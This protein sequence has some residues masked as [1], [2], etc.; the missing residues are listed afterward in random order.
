MYIR[1]SIT[2]G[3]CSRHILAYYLRTEL[4]TA[5]AQEFPCILMKKEVIMHS[6]IHKCHNDSMRS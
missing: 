2:R 3:S 6:G 4:T 5:F 1:L